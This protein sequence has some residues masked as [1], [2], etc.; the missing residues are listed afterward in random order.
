MRTL[1]DISVFWNKMSDKLDFEYIKG[2]LSALGI[3]E[4]EEVSRRLALLYFSEEHASGK[5]LSPSSDDLAVFEYYVSSGTFGNNL[6]RMKNYLGVTSEDVEVSRLKKLGY[7]ISRTFPGINYY[8]SVHPIAY[9]F[10]VTIPV[11]W[12]IRIIRGFRKHDAVKVEL[13]QLKSIK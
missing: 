1:M 10:I 5:T 11:L 6:Q 4:Y 7:L 12:A 2:E 8:R 9:R 3:S 13:G